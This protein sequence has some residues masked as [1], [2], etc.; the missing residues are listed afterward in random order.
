MST[1]NNGNSFALNLI[2][3]L[4]F[5][6]LKQFFAE[7]EKLKGTKEHVPLDLQIQDSVVMYKVLQH[8][9]A[10]PIEWNA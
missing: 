5:H 7:K 10:N 4:A 2:N 6:S 8:A 9:F 1:Q 3:S